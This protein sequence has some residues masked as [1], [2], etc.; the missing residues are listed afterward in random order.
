[1]ECNNVYDAI[2]ISDLHLGSRVCQRGKLLRFLNDI[3][4]GKIKTKFLIVNGDFLDSPKG[5][6]S[7]LFALLTKHFDTVLIRGN[8]DGHQSKLHGVEVNSGWCLLSGDKRIFIF[9]GDFVDEFIRRHP[10]ITWLAEKG[11]DL[12]QQLNLKWAYWLKHYSKTLIHCSE[13]IEKEARF[14]IGKR[15]DMVCCGHTHFA[16][17]SD[18]GIYF[19]SGCWTE[20][21]CHYLTVKDGKI[22]LHE[23]IDSH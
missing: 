4:F 21:H 23:Y 6:D 15:Y 19:N 16:K 22:E 17:A 9:H 14:I 13:Q 1:V 10:F 3:Y 5:L 12:L 7:V 11:Y 20:P 8:H 18:D 2:I